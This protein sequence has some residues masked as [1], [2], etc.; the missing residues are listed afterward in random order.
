ML[1]CDD[2]HFMRKNSKYSIDWQ[3]STQLQVLQSLFQRIRAQDELEG[4]SDHI[5][6]AYS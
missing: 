5:I 3:Q 6:I 4:H 2:G 1:F